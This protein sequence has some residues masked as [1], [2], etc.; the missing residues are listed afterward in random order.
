[1]AKPWAKKFYNSKAWKSARQAYIVKVHG[2]CEHCGAP[3]YIV[4]HKE[5]L[6]IYNID[7]PNIT[8]SEDNFQYLCLKC[9]NNKTFAKYSAVKEGL[10]FD[11]NGE[12]VKIV[13]PYQDYRILKAKDRR[14]PSD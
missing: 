13:P 10:E 11:E 12:I 2:L 6:T 1:M 14:L 5:E 7:N 4:D 3:G 9:H 8:L